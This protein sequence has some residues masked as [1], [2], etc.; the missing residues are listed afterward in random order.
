MK[1]L[2]YIFVILLTL[3]V[4]I[5][6]SAQS[7][8]RQISG[9]VTDNSGEPVVG[10]SVIIPNT[11]VGTSTDENGRYSLSVP[12][13]TR[14]VEVAFIGY[15]TETV[16]LG[17]A[18]VYDVVLKDDTT[19]LE[20]VVVVGYGVQKKVNLTGSVSSVSFDSE[21]IKS[22]P[23]FNATQA[24]SGAMPGLQVMQGSGNPYE[25]NFSVLVRG[26]GTLNSSGPLVLVD[27]MEQ[28][29]GNVNPSDI[30]SINVL[31]DAASCAIYGNRGAN[32]VILITTKNGSDKEGHHE[33][34]YDLTLSF[35]Q[36]F[37]I[38]HTVSDMATYM[39]LYNESCVNIGGAPQYSQATID[40][41]R[42][43]KADPRG[44]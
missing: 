18:S 2:K 40:Q 21:S 5:G 38:I 27:G 32:G 10:A 39:E 17:T 35:D 33:I 22:R 37:K 14:A 4:S 29:L 12:E 9:T 1:K 6:V 34:S 25:E 20:D 44:H 43:A 16:T 8:N 31:K 24:L 36:P 26:T 30:A 13:K 15:T 41:W 28:G 11:T 19:F 23:M 42:A 3:L 7:G